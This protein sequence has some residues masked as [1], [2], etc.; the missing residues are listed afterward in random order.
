V[1]LARKLKE[2]GADAIDASSGGFAGAQIKAEAEYQVPLA[3]AVRNGADI[4]VMAVGLLGNPSRDEELI[5]SGKADFIALARAAM[6]DPNWPVHARH[7]LGAA[8]YEL[9]PNPTKRVRERDRSLGLR[10]FA[11]A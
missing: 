6:E 4:P 7:E 8:D 9:W 2:L 1:V 3:A 5:A 10:S 11:K